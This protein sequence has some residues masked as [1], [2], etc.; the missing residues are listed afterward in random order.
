MAFLMPLE[1]FLW[2]KDSPTLSLILQ[3]KLRVLYWAHLGAIPPENQA[4]FV[5]LLNEI[6]PFKSITGQDWITAHEFCANSHCSPC[7]DE[8]L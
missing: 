1:E 6:L 5:L 7:G 3:E 8:E 2:H 4:D